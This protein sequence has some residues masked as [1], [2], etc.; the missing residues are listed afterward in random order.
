M[1]SCVRCTGPEKNFFIQSP[2]SLEN[3]NQAVIGPD[4]PKV[5]T[6]QSDIENMI[7]LPERSENASKEN[8]MTSNIL[9][10]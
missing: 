8:G 7:K 10:I 1:C 6:S 5:Q 9:L 3:D 2:T 4:I